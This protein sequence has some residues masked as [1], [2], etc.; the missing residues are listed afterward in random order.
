MATV[1]V[2]RPEPVNPPPTTV[3]LELSIEE[4]QVLYDITGCITGSQYN[5]RRFLTDQIRES[6]K[7]VEELSFD[8]YKQRLDMKSRKEDIVGINFESR[9]DM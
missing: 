1:K 2:N 7:Q 8:Y 3:T 4:A 9:K 5:S 6:L